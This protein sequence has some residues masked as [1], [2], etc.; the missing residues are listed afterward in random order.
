[1]EIIESYAPNVNKFMYTAFVICGQQ[2]DNQS[3]SGATKPISN[4]FCP[5]SQLNDPV[6]EWSHHAEV[7]YTANFSKHPCFLHLLNDEVP[8]AWPLLLLTVYI[9]HLSTDAQKQICV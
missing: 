2:W 7:G 4:N 3:L 9:P 5:L 8:I 6:L 1:M